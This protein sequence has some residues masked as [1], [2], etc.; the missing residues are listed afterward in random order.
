MATGGVLTVLTVAL[1]AFLLAGIAQSVTG[2]GS[3][4]V[5]APLVALVAGTSTTVVAVTLVGV[6]LTGWAALRERGHVDAPMAIRLSIAG[7]LGLP[8]GLLLL[9]HASDTM[10]AVLMAL[11]VVGA[12]LL[13]AFAVRLPDRPWATWAMGLSS[14]ALLTSTGMNGPPLVLAMV[15]RGL[16][17]HRFRATL[18]VVFLGQDLLAVVGFL[19]IGRLGPASLSV[20]AVGVVASPIGWL[21]GDR[22]FHRLSPEVF[23]RVLV[24]GLA[25]SALMLVLTHLL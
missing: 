21:L 22:V 8:L 24:V 12:L 5:S 13:V 1:L 14:G 15:A 7:L 20:A 4:L 17:P 10:L 25:C 9:A 19:L 2:F 3:A 18:Q 23:R 11:A 16:D 6:A